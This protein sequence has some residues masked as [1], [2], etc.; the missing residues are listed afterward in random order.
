VSYIRGQDYNNNPILISL[1]NK[2]YINV[3]KIAINKKEA[4]YINA[5]WLYS[6]FKGYLKLL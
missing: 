6:V 5:F 2:L 3:T 4:S 1:I